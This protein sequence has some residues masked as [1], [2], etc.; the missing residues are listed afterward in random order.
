MEDLNRYFSKEDTQMSNKH[1]KICSVSL[2]VR[3]MQNK[4]TMRYHLIPVRMAI[5]KKKN[6]YT[7]NAGEGV[8]K[9]ETSYTVGGDI[10]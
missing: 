4:T 8:E 9:R 7:I 3:E 2:I 5:I 10:N 6:L 1:I